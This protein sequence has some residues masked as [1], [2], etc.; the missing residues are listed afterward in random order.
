MTSHRLLRALVATLALLI[1][2][3]LL[4]E[5]QW[6]QPLT[7]F[8]FRT[9]FMQVSGIVAIGVMS[10]A[11]LLALRPTWLEPHLDGLDKMYRLHKWLGI[12]ALVVSVLHWWMAQGTKWMVGW[13]WLTRPV[14]GPRPAGVDQGLIEGLLGAQRALAE[15]VGEWA[16][17]AAAVL[18][19]LALVQRFPYRLFAKTHTW[20]AAIYL[21]LVFHSVV[22]VK[23]PY[24]G[25]PVGWLL[26]PLLAAG[27]VAAVLVL[28]GRVGARRKVQGTIDETHRYRALDVLETRITLRDGWRGHAAGQFAFVTADPKEGAHPYTIASAWDP[29]TRRITFITKALGDHTRRLPELLKPGMAVTVEGPY[30]RF[31][32]EDGKPRQIW[33]GAGIGITPFIARLKQLAAHPVSAGSARIDLFHTTAVEDPIALDKLRADALAAGVRLHVL[34]DA[35]DGLLDGERI[36]ALVPDW[37]Q[38]SLWFCG[39][40]PFGHSLFGDFI[41]RGLSRSVLHQELFHMR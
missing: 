30:G 5:P 41:R 37:Q 4:A 35:R 27:S 22:L 36:R 15:S 29:A 1:G 9:V 26:A 40:T 8:S 12:T 39:P 20:L 2:L 3:W 33:V 19:V 11:M 16:F 38:A 14:R 25:E 32:F 13:G 7:W 18:L 34:V 17:Y 6:P 28:I 21:V 24:W 10:V 31:D 23:F